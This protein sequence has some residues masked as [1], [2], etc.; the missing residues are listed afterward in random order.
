PSSQPSGGGGATRA[1]PPCTAARPT[2]SRCAGRRAASTRQ[3]AGATSPA[4]SQRLARRLRRVA[5]RV[6][7]AQLDR[8]AMALL[9]PAA[10]HLD[11]VRALADLQPDALEDRLAALDADRHRRVLRQAERDARGTAH[12]LQADLAE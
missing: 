2:R 11:G 6:A 12:R 3:L 4:E 10:A 1:S 8:I 5:V 7:C 9:E